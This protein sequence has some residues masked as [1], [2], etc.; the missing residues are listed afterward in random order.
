MKRDYH[1][2]HSPSLDRQMEMLVY[3]HGGTPL[4]VF[5]TSRGRFFEYEEAGMISALSYQIN[6]GCNQV[7]CVDS[8]DAESWYNYGAHSGHRLFRHSQYEAYI[9]NE[10]LPLI[11]SLNHTP[12]LV[13]TGC[14]FGAYH[15]TNLAF[16][17][18]DLIQK[19]ICLGGSFDIRQFIHGYYD[20]TAYFNAPFDYL[21]GLNDGW[22][23]DHLRRM[24]IILG[25]GERDICLQENVRLS[26]LLNDKGIGHW[27]DVW[28]N[29]TA[30]DWPWW[31]AMIQKYIG[32]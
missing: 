32:A 31:R 6:N 24:K 16:R 14:S 20:D 15:A 25:T 18:P 8:V 27:L 4:L 26:Q 1:V 2:W 30:H 5:P 3:G 29:G 28:G 17:H 13:A 7:F 21:P 19:I 23:L 9:L 12:F 11:R 10:V 22:Y